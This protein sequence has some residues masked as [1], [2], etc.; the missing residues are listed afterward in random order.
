M[1]LRLKG[2]IVPTVLRGSWIKSEM[3]RNIDDV[4]HVIFLYQNA[5][6]LILRRYSRN[7]VAGSLFLDCQP[8]DFQDC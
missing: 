7:I 6:E 4:D 2:F 5:M 1:R 8:S 3:S